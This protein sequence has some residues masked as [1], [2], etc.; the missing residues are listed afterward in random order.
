MEDGIVNSKDLD[1]DGDGC[2]DVIEAGLSDPDGD[3]ILG[4]G[5]SLSDSSSSYNFIN[6]IQASEYIGWGYDASNVYPSL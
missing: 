5:F 2:F 3:G 6:G 1:S 4:D